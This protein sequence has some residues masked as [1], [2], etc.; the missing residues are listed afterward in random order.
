MQKRARVES[1]QK[2]EIQGSALRLLPWMLIYVWAIGVIGATV[3]ARADLLVASKSGNTLSVIDQ[4]SGKQT[5]VFQTGAGPHEVE[6]DRMRRYAAISNYGTDE[7]PGHTLTLLDFARSATKTIDL[8]PETRPHGIAWLPG[9]KRLVVTT[10]GANRLS[11]V[12]VVSGTVVRAIETGGEQPHMVVVDE[13]GRFAW[14]TQVTSGT[15]SRID[16][17]Q[18]V[19]THQRATGEEA[20]GLAISPDGEKI[21]VTNRAEGSVS[22]HAADTLEEEGRVLVGGMPIRVELDPSGGSAMIVSATGGI[23]TQI[24]TASL[25]IRG[26]CSMRGQYEFSTGRFMGGGFGFLPL[27]V[28]LQ[29]N[30]AGDLF[31]VANSYGG[32]VAEVALDT[33]EIRRSWQS[34]GAEPDGMA[35]LP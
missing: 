26:E 33:L 6:L 10:E 16:L 8:S 7:E 11:I 1:E 22:V 29:F 23:V 34:G 17:E 9:S 3:P 35:W 27:P 30:S 25:E 19:V 2:E 14:V 4:E 28:G 13:A 21:W 32:V 15:L 20:E 5:A 12:D 31:Y 18:G 24:D